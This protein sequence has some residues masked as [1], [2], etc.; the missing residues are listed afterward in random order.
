MYDLRVIFSHQLSRQL[1]P[2]RRS[3]KNLCENILRVSLYDVL[4][5][6]FSEVR[7][8]SM[9]WHYFLVLTLRMVD[10]MKIDC[11]MQKAVQDKY[12]IYQVITS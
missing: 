6:E 4:R 1:R 10:V 11:L 3:Y 2:H 12:Q 8:Y 9:Q 7:K 5:L